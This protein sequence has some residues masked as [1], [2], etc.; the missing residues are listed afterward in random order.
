[1]KLTLLP[2][3]S[4]DMKD[5]I[6]MEIPDSSCFV[7]LIKEREFERAKKVF[8]NS[9]SSKIEYTQRRHIWSKTLKK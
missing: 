5:A 8:E 7:R 1:M 9:V 4:D 6:E 2:F 3:G